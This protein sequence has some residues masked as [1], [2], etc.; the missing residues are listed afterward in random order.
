[1]FIALGIFFAGINVGA[2]TF[3]DERAVFWRDTSAGMPTLP[4]YL[5]EVL[6]DVPRIIVASCMY[7][8]AFIFFFAYHEQL[9]S[10]LLLIQLLYI[11]AFAIGYFV[12][13]AVN[14][15]MFGLTGTGMSLAW[16]LVLSGTALYLYKV[17]NSSGYASVRWVWNVSAPRW[18]VEA[19]YLK[20]MELRKYNEVKHNFLGDTYSLAIYEKAILY[21]L[22]I[23]LGWNIVSFALMKLLNQHKVK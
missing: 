6:A 13:T 17:M 7:T 4:Y 22:Y 19:F 1:M 15:S 18:A 21:M 3:S 10:L 2:C 11:N 5:A 12:S 20:E 23:S 9:G 14:R 16:A 8:R